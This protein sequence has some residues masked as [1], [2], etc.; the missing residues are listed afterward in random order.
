MSGSCWKNLTHQPAHPIVPSTGRV[1][2]FSMG[3]SDLFRACRSKERKLLHKPFVELRDVVHQEHDIT[4]SNHVWMVSST[5]HLLVPE[6]YC[7]RFHRFLHIIHLMEAS[8]ISSL[9][10]RVIEVGYGPQSME[11]PKHP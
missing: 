10:S 4:K 6:S 1:T 8:D 5:N 3:D 7:G 2:V 9:S 11:S